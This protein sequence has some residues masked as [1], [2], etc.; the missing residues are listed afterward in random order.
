MA[1]WILKFQA[2]KTAKDAK[3]IHHFATPCR[4]KYKQVKRPRQKRQMR[5]MCMRQT[6]VVTVLANGR[7][8]QLK[9]RCWCITSVES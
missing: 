4:M 9:H 1:L 2:E 8:V 7:L 3:G 6:G 5:V